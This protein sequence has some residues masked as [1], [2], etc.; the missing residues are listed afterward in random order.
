M[1]LQKSGATPSGEPAN[2]EP[3]NGQTGKHG[4]N[5]TRLATLTLLEA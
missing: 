4:L 1:L 2:P 3:Y 5:T